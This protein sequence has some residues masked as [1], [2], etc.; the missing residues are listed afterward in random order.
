MGKWDCAGVRSA[1]LIEKSDSPTLAEI[2]RIAAIK[3]PVIRN[4][5]ITQCYHEL[6]GIL[7]RRTGLSANWCTFAT[8]ASKQAGQTIR[9]EDLKRLLEINFARAPMT[10]MAAESFAKSAQ[11]MGA[12]ESMQ[13]QALALDTHNFVSALD[14]ASDAVG[15]GNKKVFE[16]IGREFARFFSTCLID[17]E[18]DSKKIAHF[19]EELRPGDPPNGQEYLRQAF[20]HYY[21]ALFEEDLKSRAELILAANIKIGYHEQT[22]L[23]PEIAESLDAGLISAFEFTRRLMARIFPFYGLVTL[24]RIYLMRLFGRPTTLDQAIRALLEAVRILLRKTLTEVMM[25]ITLPSGLHLRLGEDLATGFPPSLQHITNPY[26]KSL[27]KK[28]DP[29][30]DS[31]VDS[32]AIDWADLPDRLHFIIDLFR[33]YQESQ[34]LFEPPF[35]PEQVETLKSGRLPTGRL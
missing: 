30:P 2:D 25:T 20:T 1:P 15:R 16:E 19:C 32:G 6:S 13:L 11:L 26:L 3:D 24:A 8:W 12:G 7:T 33:C 10:L 29:T 5:Q 18:P 17:E 23:Q 27:L 28:L 31:L 22:R 14:H 9:K 34:D 35:I 21:Q 4:L